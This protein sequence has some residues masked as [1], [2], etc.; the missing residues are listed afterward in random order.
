M[1]FTFRRYIV[2]CCREAPQS[3]RKA[4]IVMT[5]VINLVMLGI[6]YAGAQLTHYPTAA[7]LVGTGIIAF[8]EI[9]ILGPYKLCKSLQVD[10][11]KAK[12]QLKP[13]LKLSFDMS[14]PYCLKRDVSLND[15]HKG[16]WHRLKVE[17][18]SAVNVEH[19]SARLLDI[20]RDGTPVFA[21]ETAR[22]S[23]ALT[24]T[25]FDETVKARI[26]SVID[27]LLAAKLLATHGESC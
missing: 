23:F 22:L 15:G 26:P 6:V 8:L 13:K 10:L 19:C 21:G 27:L 11:D 14:D 17:S 9:L 3:W 7:F 25:P 4:A 5:I 12:E 16:N 2:E 24:G 20:Y 1:A 18:A